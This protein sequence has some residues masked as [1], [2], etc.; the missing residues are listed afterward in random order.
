[1]DFPGPLSLSPYSV[2]CLRSLG[3]PWEFQ[4]S[5]RLEPPVPLPP[6]YTSPALTSLLGSGSLKISWVPT[7]TPTLLQTELTILSPNLLLCCFP[8]RWMT[9]SDS[10]SSQRET[11]RV[12]FLLLPSILPSHFPPNQQTILSPKWF[13]NPSSPFLSRHHHLRSG[14]HYFYLDYFNSHWASPCFLFTY[15][16]TVT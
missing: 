3:H 2:C 11:S 4:L 6:Q 12:T 8:S 7:D 14:P 1:M 5:A 10:G 16:K 9:P 13:S 15:L